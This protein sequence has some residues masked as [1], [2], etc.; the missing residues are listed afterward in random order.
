L[1]PLLY[2]DNKQLFDVQ[3]KSVFAGKIG[4]TGSSLLKQ[5]IKRKS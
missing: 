3:I 4:Y 2:S 5:F 1:N